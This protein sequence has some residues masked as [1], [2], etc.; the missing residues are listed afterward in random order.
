MKTLSTSDQDSSLSVTPEHA[1][2][3]SFGSSFEA[4]VSTNGHTNGN[5]FSSVT[6]GNSGAGVVMGNGVSKHGKAVAKVTL[7]GTTLYD[8]SFV[9]R[10]EFIRLVIQ[11]LRD[12]GY[13]ESAAT[14][15]AESGYTME[16]AEVS[17]FRQYILDGLWSKAEAALVRL[18][19]QED[20]GLWDAKF[21]ISQQ[22]Y[23]E[24][25][26]AKKPT[27]A[28]Q[29]LRS[30]LAP[31]NVD[32]DHL[33]T[34][35]SL[36]MCSEPEDLRQRAGWDGAS[37]SS[38]RQLLDTL[39]EYI[40][41]AVMIPQRRF[42]TLLNQA[43]SYQRQRCLYHNAPLSTFSLYSDHHC[44]MSDFPTITTTILEVHSDEVW[45]IEWSHDGAYLASGSKDKSAIIWKRGSTI[46][47]TPQDWS[48]HH[49]L[50]DHPYPV[51]CLA[52]SPDDSVL[53]TSAEN[54][55]K[56]WNAKTGICIR[57]LDEHTE[58]VTAIAWLPDGTGFI[59]GALDRRI[60]VWDAEGS[61][62]NSWDPTAIRLTDLAVTPDQARLVAIG[63]ES[64]APVP[65]PSDAPHSRSA[66]TGDVLS[67][68]GGNGSPS[69]GRTPHR[70]MI[71]DLA[72]KQVQ[73]SIPIAGELTSVQTSQDSQYALVNH[74]PN[75]VL[76]Y[77]LNTGKTVMKYEGQTQGRHVIRSCF[78]GIDGNFVVSGSEDANV[79]TWH[80]ESGRLLETLS[81]HGEGS[82]NSVAWNPVNERMFAS[83]SDDH[84]I[85]I[86][87][88]PPPGVYIVEQPPV[89]ESLAAASSS[90]TSAAAVVEK[91]KGK[92][93]QRVDDNSVSTTFGATRL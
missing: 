37:G 25:V 5:G 4:L 27:E 22:K 29:V 50:S 81:G 42:S 7:P 43:R 36:I 6:N 35:S 86:W 79:Y 77:D 74:A 87:E 12:V 76:L 69:S 65:A 31:L 83:C 54:F 68:A 70:M 89:E 41:S 53:L 73:S 64:P 19:V 90:Q 51:G 67:N 39:H 47:S 24:L 58:T 60:V 80:R 38:R 63:I 44:S 16:S 14:L 55:V 1:G 92:T 2:P 49:T 26:E 30:E 34:L 71:F 46:G 23:L 32:S 85:R 52:W 84:T 45:N 56:M 48:P 15:E 20:E 18:G 82:V 91:G 59:T 33:H 11:S 28:L 9:D 3:S 66:Q 75:E 8:D 17:Q 72:T 78:G 93:R 10:E 62:R 57:T 13:V 88:A 40:P 21:L 61:I